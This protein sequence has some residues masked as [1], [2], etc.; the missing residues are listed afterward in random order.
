MLT[1]SR[2]EVG[3]VGS[4]TSAVSVS[5][6]V[7]S[8][9]GIMISFC[10][11]LDI[12]NHRTNAM[13]NPGCFQIRKIKFSIDVVQRQMLQGV[14]DK[15]GSQWSKLSDGSL[16]VTRWMKRSVKESD[17]IGSQVAKLIG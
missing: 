16:G 17:L 12:D 14:I 1:A 8:D 2:K 7:S 13:N 11:S 3:D 5:R 15:V 9:D 6:K 4:R 10:Q